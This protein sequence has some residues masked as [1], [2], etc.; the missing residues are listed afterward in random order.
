MA[1]RGAIHAGRGTSPSM[2]RDAGSH[3]VHRIVRVF[4]SLSALIPAGKDFEKCSD[5]G[6]LGKWHLIE[7]YFFG[8]CDRKVRDQ[9]KVSLRWERIYLREVGSAATDPWEVMPA[10]HGPIY[11]GR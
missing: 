8:V 2:E 3:S 1:T 5:S 4:S 9:A 11:P 10:P 7:V 6:G